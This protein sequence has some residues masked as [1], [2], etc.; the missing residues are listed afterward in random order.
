MKLD[1]VLPDEIKDALSL[2]A[3]AGHPGYVVGGAIR[4][5]LFKRAPK[6]YDIT[7]S[8][9]PE[10]IKVIFKDHSPFM[11]GAFFATVVVVY[12]HHTPI[13]ITTF[14]TSPE[15]GLVTRHP[16]AV[17]YGRS[18]EE[19]SLT[20]DFTI[21]AIAIDKDNNL[22]DY[23]GGCQ[24][25]QNHLLRAV[26]NPDDRFREDPLRLLRF[27]RFVGEYGLTPDPDTWKAIP[28]NA[29]LLSF[30]SPER[31]RDTFRMMLVTKPSLVRQLHETGLLKIILPEVEDL[32]SVP[33]HNPGHYTD[34]GNHTL[35]ALAYLETFTGLCEEDRSLLA[36]AILFHDLGKKKTRT[37]DENGVD[38]FYQ[39]AK[40]SAAETKAILEHYRYKKSDSE[41]ILKLVANHDIE[42]LPTRHCF[43]RLIGKH[44]FSKHDFYLLTL[45]KRADDAAHINGQQRIKDMEPTFAYLMGTYDDFAKEQESFKITD[46]AL[47]G[48]D[49]MGTLG[50]AP[51]KEVG[52]IKEEL[53]EAVVL[54]KVSN[55]RENLLA[56]L[57]NIR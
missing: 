42:L 55:T 53:F 33:Q 19:D 47:D 43:L 40:E 30:V 9:T 4:D 1:L 56:Y 26:G 25:I 20:R 37:T 12:N 10:E 39:H 29:S 21:N 8:A 5:T 14:K 34:V 46:L 52:K 44:G 41:T 27:F 45:V 15:N 38:H 28:R 54:G 16:G 36:N 11:T 2:L 22:Y 35:D 18:L 13:E 17:L 24:D 6:D 57:K 23:Q 31:I 51:G 50:I 7:T 32:F 3:K 49:I 48:K